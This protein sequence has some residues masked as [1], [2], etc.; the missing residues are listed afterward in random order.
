M[1]LTTSYCEV[2]P[3]H[4][5]VRYEFR[6]T[7]NAAAILAAT[8]APEFAD[9]CAVL[10]GFALGTDDLINPGGN[11]SALAARLN[12]E[13]RARGWRES[14][15]DT[16][17]ISEFRMYPY[18]LAGELKV[19]TEQ[20][21]VFSEGYKVDNVKGRIALDVE[22]NA[23]DGNLDRDIGAYRS[24]YDTGRIDG[25]VLIT[26]TQDDLRQLAYRLATE[27]G[28]PEKEARG[29]LG[30]TTTTNLAKLEPRMA[31]GDTG[32]CPLL[33]VAISSRCWSAW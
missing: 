10:E 14:R 2:V 5:R 27:A 31:R 30:T 12:G 28:Q 8:S 7:R 9:L 26:R 29:R 18:M 17:I 13:F 16:R 33:A 11:Q 20:S 24:L 6:E 23:K 21:E 22:W 3:D 4:V 19:K 32:G 1:D 15:V 25:A